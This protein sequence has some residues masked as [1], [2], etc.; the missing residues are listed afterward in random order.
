MSDNETEHSTTKTA[1]WALAGLGAVFL[2]RKVLGSHS[3]PSAG[4]GFLQAIKETQQEAD[5]VSPEESA[6]VRARNAALAAAATTSAV[7]AMS[8]SM[9]NIA[10]NMGPDRRR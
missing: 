5:R 10:A 7:D 8:R 2:A 4:S 3:K 1:L 6:R 9:S